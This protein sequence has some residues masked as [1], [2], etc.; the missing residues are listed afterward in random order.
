MLHALC[1]RADTLLLIDSK[2]HCVS[3]LQANMAGRQTL[4]EITI[5]SSVL[6]ILKVNRGN[7]STD[8]RDLTS[9]SL[10][11]CEEVEERGVLH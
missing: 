4:V 10:I 1:W 2:G 7:F 5:V 11:Y 6:L 3:V 8:C 9:L